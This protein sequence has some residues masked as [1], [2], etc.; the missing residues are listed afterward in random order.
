ML[1]GIQIRVYNINFKIEM[2]LLRISYEKMSSENS[3]KNKWQ[4][5]KIP[6]LFFTFDL[7]V[8]VE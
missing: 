7:Q 8:D 2:F 5:F 6:K 1:F 4:M 3:K